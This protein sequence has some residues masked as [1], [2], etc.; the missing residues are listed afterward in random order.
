MQIAA[1]LRIASY[2]KK[3][4]LLHRRSKSGCLVCRQR[5]KKCDENRPRCDVCTRTDSKCQWPPEAEVAARSRTRGFR[6]IPTGPTTVSGCSPQFATLHSPTLLQH[7]IVETAPQL[8]VSGISPLNPFLEVVIPSAHSNLLLMHIILI[9]SGA[10]LSY[11]LADNTLEI[12]A[13]IHIHY[14]NVIQS[15]QTKI[16]NIENFTASSDDDGFFLALS[17]LCY[18]EVCVLCSN[19]TCSSMIGTAGAVYLI[20]YLFPRYGHFLENQ[21]LYG[22]YTFSAPKRLLE[23]TAIDRSTP[24]LALAYE[25]FSNLIFVNLNPF[26]TDSQDIHLQEV[27]KLTPLYEKTSDHGIFSASARNVFEL[28]LHARGI[29]QRKPLH[30]KVNDFTGACEIDDECQIL[31]RKIQFWKTQDEYIIGSLTSTE[32]EQAQRSLA[33]ERTRHGLQIYAAATPFGSSTIPQDVK[34][35]LESH[36]MKILII[37]A[38]LKDLPSACNILCAIVMAGSC[39]TQQTLKLELAQGLTTSKF[40]MRHLSSIRNALELLWNGPDPQGY[41]PHGLYFI[42]A[43]Y[44]ANISIL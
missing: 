30:E 6:L 15:I 29:Y 7:Y 35:I 1:F 34:V 18:Y 16:D 9:L 19:Q 21:R 31:L 28:V 25:I 14:M 43:K 33:L 32:Q 10:H 26:S 11:K 36:A 23:S 2:P 17:L 38:I 13:S 8:A 4:R 5:R 42:T 3:F 39:I 12:D 20:I 22:G 27:L 37:S 44:D 24:Q 41:G 40:Q